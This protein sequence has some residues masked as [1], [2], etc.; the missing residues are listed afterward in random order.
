MNSNIH[1]NGVRRFSASK[2]DKHWA[3]WLEIYSELVTPESQRSGFGEMIGRGVTHTG[4]APAR[5]YYV[6]LIFYFN[7]Y[8]GCALPLI[9]LQHHEVKIDFE[10]RSFL[11][12]LETDGTPTVASTEMGNTTLY[13]DYVFLDG[14]ERRRFA[15]QPHEYLID[16]LQFHGANTVN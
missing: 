2:C 6:P 9:A 1:P 12:L 3:E 13:V 10:F 5:T 8:Y 4:Y 16:Q 15:R 7:R 14:E 11:E